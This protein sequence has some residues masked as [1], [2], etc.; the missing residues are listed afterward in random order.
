MTTWAIIGHGRSPEGQRWGP[1]IDACTVVRMWDWAPWQNPDD[2]GERYDYGL[3]ELGSGITDTFLKHKKREP[4]KGWIGSLLHTT[5]TP[6]PS[7]TQIVDQKP[8][9]AIGLR[10]GGRGATGRLQFTRGTIAACWAIE[11]SM[12]D[13]EV[14]LVGFDVIHRGVSLGINDDFSPE[15]Q[16]NPGSFP[17]KGWRPGMKKFGNH[18]Y[19]V[20]RKVLEHLADQRNVVLSFAQDVWGE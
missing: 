17:F 18:D 12:P 9:N 16:K 10:L 8:W 5:K 20:E 15:Y 1:K 14:I 7:R 3:F 13:D 11:K 2:Y 19:V 4:A 6:I